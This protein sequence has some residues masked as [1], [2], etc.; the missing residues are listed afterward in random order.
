MRTVYLAVTPNRVLVFLPSSVRGRAEWQGEVGIETIRGTERIEH[1]GRLARR[2]E[3]PTA[4]SLWWLILDS[5]VE[6][7]R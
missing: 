5:E 7:L 2:I 3:T 6:V 1:S 4:G